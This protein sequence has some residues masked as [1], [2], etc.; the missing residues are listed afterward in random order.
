MARPKRRRTAFHMC[1]KRELKGKPG[2]KS[3]FKAAVRKCKK[4]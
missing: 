3:R 2:S 4:K 1:M